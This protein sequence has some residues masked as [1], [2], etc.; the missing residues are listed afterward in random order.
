MFDKFTDRARKVMSLARQEAQRFNHEYIG[1]EHILLGLV[2]EGSGLAARVL[3]NLDV[4]LRKI[5]TAVEKLIPHGPPTVQMGQLP[6]TPRAKRVLEL[7][8]GEANQLGHDHIGTEHLLL[9]LLRENEGV[10]AQVLM[11]LGLKLE[12]VREEVLEVLGAACDG[13]TMPPSSKPMITSGALT[14][15]R[16][17]L[18][19][20]R[21]IAA[22]IPEVPLTLERMSPEV[23]KALQAA[24]EIARQACQSQVHAVHVF[25]ALLARWGTKA[26]LYFK[27][28]ESVKLIRA[29][30]EEAP[31][32]QAPTKG[33]LSF[34]AVV[35][36]AMQRAWEIARRLGFATVEIDHA[37]V[38]LLQD[39]E[40]A[41]AKLLAPE[42][43]D[44]PK[45]RRT[46]EEELTQS[47]GLALPALASESSPPVAMAGDVWQVLRTARDEAVRRGQSRIG[48]A[49][50]VAALLPEE[51]DRARQAMNRAGA[52]APPEAP[53][54]DVHA[55]EAISR[56]LGLAHAMGFAEA[57]ALHLEVGIL[58][59]DPMA[60]A[61]VLDGSPQDHRRRRQGVWERLYASA[62]T[63]PSAC[64]Q[65]H[66][67]TDA[68]INA[69]HRANEIAS[70]EGAPLVEP[71]YLLLALLE[72]Q[73]GAAHRLLEVVR[74][75]RDASKLVLDRRSR[76]GFVRPAADVRLSATTVEA[77]AMAAEEAFA[78][79]SEAIDTD[80]LL[81]G[82]LRARTTL[83]AQALACVGA[84]LGRVRI[85]ALELDLGG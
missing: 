56:A 36:G 22:P 41:I 74:I 54:F 51:A 34:P 14:L 42:T 73:R 67:L 71:Q 53:E 50:L 26:E 65:A 82:L 24:T 6:F 78:L 39:A 44:L 38:V 12:D 11:N 17:V 59:V 9:G 70:S 37:M 60:R 49:H 83:A 43:V 72:D 10:A 2:Q 1:T 15:D 52:P 30:L 7:A 4:D 47:R 55:S 85:A 75:D 3:K 25:A 31:P 13:T 80:H 84:S 23:R 62:G 40:E 68:S 32:G 66:A 16:L 46:L 28:V 20:A 5:R 76:W 35:E 81:L 77:V 27:G 63:I 61:E 64:G 45:V 33:E 58:S 8:Q 18:V 57:T 79:R 29:L 69:L 19:L 48:L 21:D